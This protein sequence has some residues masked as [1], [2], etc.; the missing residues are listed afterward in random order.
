MT[1]ASMSELAANADARAS[2]VGECAF[3]LLPEAVG[4]VADAEAGPDFVDGTLVHAGDGL[5]FLEVDDHAAVF[6]SGA[7]GCVGVAAAL[8]LDLRL[9]LEKT[10]Y[11]CA[12]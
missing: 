7:E 8:G 6:A 5:E 1:V 10:L 4:E 12:G 9:G 3:A 2:S 11:I